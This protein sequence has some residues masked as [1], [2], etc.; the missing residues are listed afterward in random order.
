[1]TQ[2]EKDKF[3]KV[4][5]NLKKYPRIIDIAVV[6]EISERTV[7]RYSSKFR[8]EDEDL[9]I[10]RS[11]TQ[12]KDV[13]DEFLAVKPSYR[14]PVNRNSKNERILVISDM[15]VPFHHPDAFDFLR[16][17]KKKYKPDRIVCIGD[18]CF[19]P[20]AEILTDT[21]WV[22]FD[23]YTN[24]NVAQ[25]NEEGNVDFVEPI[26]FFSKPT[27]QP[28]YEMKHSTYYSLTTPR[29]KI[30]KI[31]PED[32]KVVRREA[33]DATGSGHW[34]IPRSGNYTQGKGIGLT[35]N[36]IKLQTAFQADGT[37][38]KGAIKFEFSKDRKIVRLKSILDEI[39]LSYIERHPNT[40]ETTVIYIKKCDVPVYIAKKFDSLWIKE[41]NWDQRMCFMNELVHWDGT[42]QLNGFRYVS[43]VEHNLDV[44]QAIAVTTGI[45]AKKTDNRL[46]VIMRDDERTTQRSAETSYVDYEGLVYCVS[47]PTGMIIVRQNGMVNVTGNCDHNAMSYHETDP[48]TFSA[49]YELLRAR[50]FIKEWEKIFPEMDLVDSNHG[51]LYYRKAKTAGI[52]REAIVPYNELL[53]VGNGWKWQ[54]DLTLTMSNDERVYFHHGI[55]SEVSKL[56]ESLG[57]SAV[58]GHFHN[59]YSIKY[60]GN[61]DRLYFGLQVGCMIDD[62]ALAF[63]YNKTTMKRPIIGCAII[64]NGLPRL[65][66]L[67]KDKNGRWNKVVP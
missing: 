56:S 10:K 58:Q 21:G 14:T 61:P 52:P 11:A 54:F 64:E 3:V 60:S 27:I 62:N 46:D 49:G 16:A 37:F 15:H 13:S 59:S 50:E 18:E 48:N 25:W 23:G 28:L 38:D 8:K 66:P 30:V 44:V 39:G 17:L 32:G 53:G 36:E 43:M 2:N 65:L 47:V 63:N 34:S 1:M 51:S 35:D 40:R 12:K 67:I 45:R 31:R 24:E 33:I 41:M 55:V 20:E 57:M 19:P 26:R 29:H 22:R 4:Y 42:K 7:R 6:L 9:L 5:N